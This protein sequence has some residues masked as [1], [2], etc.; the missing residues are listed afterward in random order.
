M[1]VKKKSKYL[2]QL[3]FLGE[4]Q[5]KEKQNKKKTSFDWILFK[6]LTILLDSDVHVSFAIW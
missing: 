4:V 6:I 2:W 5:G 3:F 1:G